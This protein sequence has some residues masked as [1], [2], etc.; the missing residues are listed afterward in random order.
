MGRFT[1]L[2]LRRRKTPAAKTAPRPALTPE[3]VEDPQA[4]ADAEFEELKRASHEALVEAIR[5]NGTDGVG[6]SDGFGLT[7]E[8][9]V[10]R[11]LG[12]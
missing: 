2:F 11:L 7:R 9:R 6:F 5:R 12:R 3:P 10:A 4:Q 1:D 8:Q